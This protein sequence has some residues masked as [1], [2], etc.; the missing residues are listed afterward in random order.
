MRSVITVLALCAWLSGTV[1]TQDAAPFRLEEATVAGI[2]A[3]FA[4]G[5][6]TCAQL[7]R[8][9]LDR[10]EAYDRKGPAL[11]SIITINPFMALMVTAVYTERNREVFRDGMRKLDE[12]CRVMNGAPFMSAT[13]AQRLKLLEELD[14][15]QKTAMAERAAPPRSRAPVATSDNDQPR[16]YFRLM[17]ELA[18]QGYFTSEIGYTRAMRYVEAPGRYD[19]CTPHAPGDKTWASHA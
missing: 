5:R 3:A 18:L 11:R 14:R 1:R 7:T 12:A 8:G 10:I 13:P 15:E 19:P 16:H 17:K 4:A 2:H 6:L 9:Y